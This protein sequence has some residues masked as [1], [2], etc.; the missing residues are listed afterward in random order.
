[1]NPAPPVEATPL[2]T[3]AHVQSPRRSLL[4]YLCALLAF[5]AVCIALRKLLPLHVAGISY[6]LESFAAQKDEF[7]VVSIGTSRVYHGVVPSVFDDKARALGYAS[8]SFNGGADGM[9]TSEAFAITRRILGQ[10]PRRLRY[11]LFELESGIGAG[12]PLESAGVTVRNVYWRDWHSLVSAVRTFADGISWDD[13]NLSGAPFSWRRWQFF[14]PIF[15]ANVRLWARHET[16]LGEGFDRV[17]QAVAV[18]RHRGFS[19]KPPAPGWDGYYAMTRPMSGKTLATYR[20]NFAK[21]RDHPTKRK[22]DPVMQAELARY[23]R[24]LAAKKIEVIFLVPPALTNRRGAGSNCPPGSPLL[25][26]DDYERYPEFYAEEF[27]LDADHLNDRGAKLFSARLAADFVR[28]IKP[29]DR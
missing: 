12:T 2:R 15:S 7:D 23:V 24:R 17:K 6:K 19:D 21:V 27:R 4:C 5:V 1:M 8:R 22:P 26:Y 11:L 13:P 10:R 28:T 20:K 18:L 25:D 14:G 16:G 9:A 3:V 29:P